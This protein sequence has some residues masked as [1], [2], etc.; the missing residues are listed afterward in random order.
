MNTCHVCDGEGVILKGDDLWL[1]VV[2]CPACTVATGVVT[3][4]VEP[5]VLWE[6]IGGEG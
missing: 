5:G 2:D 6:D 4:A 3:P 1:G